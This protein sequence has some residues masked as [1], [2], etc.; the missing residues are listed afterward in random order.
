MPDSPSLTEDLVVADAGRRWRPPVEVRAPGGS[1]TPP[2][3]P[4]VT[5]AGPDPCFA[6]GGARFWRGTGSR[7]I[8]ALCH[9]PAVS[10]LVV[11]GRDAAPAEIAAVVQAP[12]AGERETAP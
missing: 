11:E 1:E 4:G 2:L 8:C 3:R 10:G 6:C 7:W 12:L 9:P 5:P